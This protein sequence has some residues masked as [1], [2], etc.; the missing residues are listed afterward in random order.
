[1]A[2]PASENP[3]PRN[4]ALL[5]SRSAASFRLAPEHN[6]IVNHDYPI[7]DPAIHFERASH[8]HDRQT[9]TVTVG[10]TRGGLSTQHRDQVTVNA[11]AFNASLS[12]VAVPG[13]AL[14]RLQ[15]SCKRVRY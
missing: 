7:P 11:G 8:P 9:G 4:R 6:Q 5:W 14:W 3:R 12:R 15:P 1:M 10:P 13:L 2:D